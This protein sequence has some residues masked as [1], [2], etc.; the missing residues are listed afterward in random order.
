[1]QKNKITKLLLMVTSLLISTNCFS[2]KYYSYLGSCDD[3]VFDFDFKNEKYTAY[4]QH[5]IIDKPWQYQIIKKV[6]K[7]ENQ[8]T[9][10][11][12]PESNDPLLLNITEDSSII[13]GKSINYGYTFFYKTCGVNVAKNIIEKAIAY[14][15][16]ITNRLST[17]AK[18]T[19]GTREK[20][21]R[22][23]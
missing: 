2:E 9:Y 7:K 19:A 5:R 3:G 11:I 4:L 15:N 13:H 21:S 12:S 20:A 14:N 8:E 10:I 17:P 6:L 18:G 16:R 23:P 1:M 22:A